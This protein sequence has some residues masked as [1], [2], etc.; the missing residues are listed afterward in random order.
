VWWRW[1]GRLLIARGST[2]NGN[3]WPPAAAAALLPAAM[4]LPASTGCLP[5]ARCCGCGRRRCWLAAKHT[6]TGTVL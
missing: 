3:P 1:A 2:Q 6:C 4:P 5:L